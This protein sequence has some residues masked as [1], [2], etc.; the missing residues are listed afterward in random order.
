MIA[1]CGNPKQGVNPVDGSVRKQELR[2]HRMM[3]ALPMYC[4]VSATWWEPKKPPLDTA[5]GLCDTVVSPPEGSSG[6]QR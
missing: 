5:P 1:V 4:G 6:I 3:R 2:V